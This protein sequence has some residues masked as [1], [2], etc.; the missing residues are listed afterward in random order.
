MSN[1]KKIISS[2]KPTLVDFY[3]DWCGPCKTMHPILDAVKNH[4]N[5]K[6]TVL[7]INVD[8]NQKA[9]THFKIRS[10]PTLLCFQSGEIVWRINGTVS[11]KELINKLKSF[12]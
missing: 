2:N 7:K 6:L 1:F 9:A 4:Y 8:K 12:T 3:A 5:E 11:E 10:I